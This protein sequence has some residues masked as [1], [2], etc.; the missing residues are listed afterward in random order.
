MV[1]PHREAMREGLRRNHLAY[2][3]TAKI[4]IGHSRRLVLGLALVRRPSLRGLSGLAETFL[5][6]GRSWW[7]GKKERAAVNI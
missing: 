4:N 6:R 5:R 3:K 2:S 7:R 1:I